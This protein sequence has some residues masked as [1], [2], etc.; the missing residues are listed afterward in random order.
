MGRSDR[1]EKALSFL[2]RGRAG[3]RGRRTALVVAGTLMAFQALAVIGATSASAAASCTTSGGTVTVTLPV[4]AD[5]AEVQ[6]A[7][8]GA[9]SGQILVNG[10]SCAPVAIFATTTSISVTG[11]SGDELLTIDMFDTDGVTVS[12]GTINW[13]VNLG[14]SATTGPGDCVVAPLTDGD[15]LIV[16]NSGGD[17]ALD[18]VFGASG[19]DLN[20]DGDLDVTTSSVESFNVEGDD[21]TTGTAD[22]VI[23]G[24][25]STGTGA[26]FATRLTIN[27]N[28]G[29]DTLTGGTANDTIDGDEGRDTVA[30]GLG[31][32]TLSDTGGDTN[33]AV[34][35]ATSATAVTVNLTSNVATGEGLDT[36]SGFER[37]VGS[38]LGDTLTG[39][40]VANRITP[41]AGDD[42]VDG[43]GGEIDVVSYSNST[44]AVTVD[45]DAGTAT[46]FGNDTLT[47]IEGAIGSG[48]A[49]TL[50]GDSGVNSLLGGSGNDTIA[51]LGGGTLAVPEDLEGE[52]G[53]DTV[54]YSWSADDAV[55]VL[56]SCNSTDPGSGVISAVTVDDIFTME[57][58]ILTANDDTFGGNQFGNRVWPMGGQNSLDGD[59]GQGLT[60]CVVG[61]GGDTLDYSVGYTAGVTVN[62][63]GGSVAGDAA[64]NFENVVATPFKDSVT[65]NASSN[66]VQ[67][68]A[69]K[70]NLKGGSGDDIL[71]GAKGNDIVRGGSGDDDMFGGPGKKD[72]GF[73]G[74]G[75]DLCRG[76]EFRRGCEL[77]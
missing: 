70:D 55:A 39:S 30:G 74:S 23:S 62:L 27:G 6:R 58:A 26:A 33:D 13:T 65:G 37:I 61:G 75:T 46:G 20:N 34:S 63:A 41:G 3:R 5:T 35:Y 7:T 16:D 14:S 31:D 66:T 77:R 40:G 19:I 59:I 24:A 47:S 8:S 50:S 2:D 73:G 43:A 49:D 10:A 51:G 72:R 57:N 64:P 60:G 67:G 48:F 71:R 52:G 32:D 9:L 45:L 36:L 29:D 44:A 1:K 15:C 17:D 54:D 42:K 28:G 68:R 69:G 12:W 21:G 11:A 18:T 56:F 25:G 38:P 53:V 22:D 4:A 76:F